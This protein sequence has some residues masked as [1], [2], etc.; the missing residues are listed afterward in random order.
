VIE[1]AV[2]TSAAGGSPPSRWHRVTLA[3][4]GGLVAASLV[5]FLIAAIRTP[6]LDPLPESAALF[7][8]V[9]TAGAISYQLL[10]W[11]DALGYPAAMLTGGFVLIILALVAAGTYGPVGPRTNPI[12]P[13]SYVALAV[14]V[15]ITAGV[16][17]R[18]GVV[19]AT[20]SPSQP[21]S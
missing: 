5:F 9:T 12:G 16:A 19:V 13:T 15:I 1:V 3:L 6:G 11:G 4:V 8:V 20:S 14:A 10:R 18:K 17:S 2:K 7:V 21:T